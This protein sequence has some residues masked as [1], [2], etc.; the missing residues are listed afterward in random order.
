VRAKRAGMGLGGWRL[1]HVRSVRFGKKYGPLR[2]R[3]DGTLLC[4]MFSGRGGGLE[5]DP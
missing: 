5:T 4:V 3:S 2:H 1:E